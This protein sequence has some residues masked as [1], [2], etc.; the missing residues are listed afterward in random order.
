MSGGSSDDATLAI[1]H[2]DADGRAIVDRVMNQGQQAPFDPR[3]AV[4]RFVE[5]LRSYR[6]ARVVGDRYAGETFRADFRGLGVDYIV[7]KHTTSQNYEALEPHLNG[8]AVVLPDVALLEQQLLGLIWRGGKIDHPGGEHDDFAAAV[9]GV[10]DL[11]MQPQQRGGYM[12]DCFTGQRLS[13]DFS[14]E[15]ADPY[16]HPELFE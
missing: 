13:D 2:K 7:A 16:D 14:Y 1:G 12:F 4:V 3:L 8:A 11:I 15:D 10:V 5:V 6:V 9:A